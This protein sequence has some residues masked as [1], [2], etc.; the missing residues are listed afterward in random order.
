MNRNRGGFLRAVASCAVGVAYCVAA[1][2]ASAM[3][4]ADVKRV[5][6]PF[7]VGGEQWMEMLVKLGGVRRRYGFFFP[8]PAPT[9]FRPQMYLINCRVSSLERKGVTMTSEWLTSTWD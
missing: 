4:S 2:N 9:N 7:A 1:W 6:R 5:D 3:D 8:T